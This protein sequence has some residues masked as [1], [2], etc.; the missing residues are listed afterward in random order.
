MFKSTERVRTCKVRSRTTVKK[1][2]KVKTVERVRVRREEQRTTVRRKPQGVILYRGPSKLNGK[3]IVVVATGLA[4]KSKNPK[5]GD[6]LQTWIL[7]DDGLDPVQAAATGG[8]ASVCGNCVH[9]PQKQPDGKFKLGSCYVNVIFGPLEVWKTVQRGGYPHF[10]EREHG[11]LFKC[12][13][14]RLG[15]YGDPGAVPLRVWKKVTKL[16]EHWT[17]YTHQWRTCHPG[18]ARYCMASVETANQAREAWAKG[19]RTFRVRLEEQP[20]EHGEFV[21]PASKEGGYRKTC[22]ECGACSGTKTGGRNASPVIVVHGSEAGGYWKQRQ[23]VQT[24][25]RL[26]AEEAAARR[27]FPL[28]TVEPER[29]D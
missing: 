6:E 13:M 1:G 17:G 20:V 22:E 19:W 18:L 2:G 23:Y 3:P 4:R 27:L 15:S 8:E 14:I 16:V 29:R 7:P 28:S 12:R 26:H 9:R 25:A 10:D 5:T 21:C 11:R 24:M